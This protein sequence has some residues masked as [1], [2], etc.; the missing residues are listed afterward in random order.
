MLELSP[1]ATTS[2]G[3]LYR[4]LPPIEQF[5]ISGLPHSPALGI[6]T[7]LLLGGIVLLLLATLRE[8]YQSWALVGI[9]LALSAVV[10]LIAGRFESQTAVASALRWLSAGYLFV[11]SAAVW[12]R[13]LW[14]NRLRSLGL[15]AKQPDARG[16]RI[17]AV[18]SI[19]A[20]A[21]APLII[22]AVYVATA[23]LFRVPPSIEEQSKLLLFGFIFGA[24]G[25]MTV[26]TRS[27]ANRRQLP[28]FDFARHA[29]TLLLLI[30]AAPLL[31][32]SLYV[33]GS[34]LQHRP[35]HG[36]DPASVF[37][38]MGTAASYSIP[39]LLTALVLTGYAIRE[40][41]SSFAFAGGLLLAVAATAAYLLAVVKS[42]SGLD[43]VQWVRLSQLNAA[44]AAI[45]GLA[46][47]GAIAFWLRRR[48]RTV[49]S[50]SVMT[51]SKPAPSD[52]DLTSHWTVSVPR[53]KK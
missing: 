30:T 31:S 7:W 26:V 49:P 6:G 43:T 4:H 37:A 47:T 14:L 5:E 28:I 25:V 12:S 45:Y 50:G 3:T 27:A 17:S 32:V 48:S 39:I 24:L 20:L 36:P 35:V 22:M 21:L 38:Q 9:L 13:N 34:A 51:I 53:L 33:L 2:D 44:V 23:A 19:F 8:R 40:R 1:V 11:G 15:A 52:A 42:G 18:T 16:I 46:W 10:P 41:D 29:S